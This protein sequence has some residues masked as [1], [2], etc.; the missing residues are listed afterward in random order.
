MDRRLYRE[1][2]GHQRY[3]AQYR[4]PPIVVASRMPVGDSHSEPKPVVSPTAKP[5]ASPTPATPQTRF[6]RGRV[7][8]VV[9]L[10]AVSVSPARLR[11]AGG[12][13]AAG[14]GAWV[15]GGTV[16]RGA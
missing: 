7:M 6:S 2:I 13:T 15:G 16:G 14:G 1:T 3:A 5:L 12:A 8:D 4:K 10:R 9:P 11:A